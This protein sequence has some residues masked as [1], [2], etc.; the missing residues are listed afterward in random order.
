MPVENLNA[1]LYDDD[2]DDVNFVNKTESRVI[3]VAGGQN[4]TQTQVHETSIAHN[5]HCQLCAHYMNQNVAGKNKYFFQEQLCGCTLYMYHA[6]EV[7]GMLIS[8]CVAVRSDVTLRLIVLLQ[9]RQI[10]ICF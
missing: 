10:H 5:T 7:S 1:V 6:S 9:K 3:C 2:D 8:S 4:W